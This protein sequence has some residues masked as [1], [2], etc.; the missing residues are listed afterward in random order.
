MSTICRRARH[1]GNDGGPP[2]DCRSSR[3]GARTC[4]WTGLALLGAFR[5][6]PVPRLQEQHS[7]RSQSCAVFAMRS[8]RSVVLR[9]YDAPQT[10]TARAALAACPQRRRSISTGPPATPFCTASSAITSKRSEPRPPRC[11][12]ARACLGW[13]ILERERDRFC[14]GVRHCCDEEEAHRSRNPTAV[15][16]AHE[17]LLKEAALRAIDLPSASA[18]D[19]QH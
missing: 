5:D 8:G 17:H 14:P 6:H 16:F 2:T 7:V 13:Q 3:A 4:R 1:R 12:T 9:R 10:G 11:A 19:R 15:A 18:N